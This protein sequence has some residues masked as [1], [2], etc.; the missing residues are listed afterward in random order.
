MR[1]LAVVFAAI[2]VSAQSPAPDLQAYEQALAASHRTAAAA[3]IDKLIEQRTPADGKPHPDP[4]LNALMGRL[5]LDVRQPNTAGSY[6]DNAPIDQ[7]PVAIQAPTALAHGQTLEYRG[8]RATALGA[9]QEA[10]VVATTDS[11]RRRAALGIAR[12]LLPDRPSAA[13]AKVAAIASGASVPE[14]WEARWLLAL[15]SSIAGDQIGASKSADEAWRDAPSAPLTDLAPLFVETLQAGLAAARHDS[16]M[17]RAMLTASNGLSASASANLGSQL[18]VCGDHGLRPSDFVIFGFVAAPYVNERIF[19]IAASRP[20][21]IAPFQDELAGAAPIERRTDRPS[22][23]TVFKVACRSVVS[24]TYVAGAPEDPLVDW[25]VKEGVYPASASNE[26]D[27]K[28][29]NGIA[30]RIDTLTSRF[31]RDSPLLI[32][33]RWQMLLLLEKRAL[34]GDQVPAGQLS[35]LGNQV[36]AGMRRAGAPE[37]MVATIEGR[38]KYR[39]AAAAL[40]S[41]PSEISDIRTFAREQIL[42]TPF[43]FARQI[44][45]GMLLKFKDD[46]PAQASSMLID[47]NSSARPALSGRERQAWLLTIA[48]AQRALGKDADARRTL[49]AADL[50][51]G[52]CT[53]S[54]SEPKLLEQ[55]FSYKDY[56]EDLIA[57]EQEGSVLFD[58]DLSPT[59]TVASDR[60]IY[61]LPAGLFDA[62]SAKGLA[63]VRYTQPEKAGKPAACRGVFQPIIWRLADDNEFETPR[64]TAIM[65]GPTT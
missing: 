44:F 13:R 60:A 57:G 28:H 17:E 37:W 42:R 18:P 58:F 32:G 25:F 19:P 38:P 10:A 39:E 9:Y 34:T 48:Q 63:T 16:A 43:R 41:D 33:P 15:S 35:D 54:D 27:D 29:V 2:A 51:P 4:L 11:E 52:L 20:E 56:P 23:G 64:F 62:A 46:W 55:H 8:D 12:Q 22:V 50:P 31:G 53:M 1:C 7:L 59:G 65:A 45:T 49:A 14:R 5:Y 21:V 36:A 40:A 3:V 26:A 30:D 6:L 61:S 47:F 24:A